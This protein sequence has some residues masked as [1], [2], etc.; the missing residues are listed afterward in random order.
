MLH[1]IL[2]CSEVTAEPMRVSEFCRISACNASGGEIGSGRLENSSWE[3][4]NGSR[5][6]ENWPRELRN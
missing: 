1:G 5:R 4:Q 3:L 6:L 2:L